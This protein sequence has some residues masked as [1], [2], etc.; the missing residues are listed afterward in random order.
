[1]RWFYNVVSWH[2]ACLALALFVLGTTALTAKVTA[3]S[4]P[5]PTTSIGGSPPPTSGG[6]YCPCGGDGCAVCYCLI[7]D[8]SGDPAGYTCSVDCGC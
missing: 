2:L 8:G 7:G 4:P 1:M 3:N 5:P 6:N